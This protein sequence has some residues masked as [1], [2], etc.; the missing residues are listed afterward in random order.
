MNLIYIL[1]WIALGCSI[2]LLHP[3][4]DAKLKPFILV[5]VVTVLAES[6]GMYF[7]V[8]LKE[9]NH[10]IYNFS[11]PIIIA[12]Y[13]YIVNLQTRTPY[14]RKL[15]T[16]FLT[17]YILFT[18]INPLFIQQE[19]RF[20]TY[21]YIVGA[22]F[23]TITCLLY[24]YELIKVPDLINVWKTPLFWIIWG[25]LAIYIPKA[26]LYS[27]FEYLTYKQ[28]VAASFGN[29]FHL[30]NKILSIFYFGFISYGSLCRLIYRN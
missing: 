14:F 24:L 16:I 25:V 18:I 26:I 9:S 8:V 29:T 28:E 3:N 4:N 5:M 19:D 12:L 2:F 27:M 11:V 20:L 6:L 1:E 10:T 21:T 17:T 7:R 30:V 23:L 13:I 22:F 15:N